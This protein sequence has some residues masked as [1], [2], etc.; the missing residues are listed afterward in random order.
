M[1]RPD[2]TH[3]IEQG[4][5]VYALAEATG[6]AWP[7]IWDDPKNA[8]LKK[9]RSDPGILLPGDVVHIPPLRK[10][11]ESGSDAAKHRF[12]RLSIPLK[13]RIRLQR[14]GEPRIGQRFKVTIGASSQHGN[15]DGDGIAEV[16]LPRDAR[17]AILEVG[18]GDE[19]TIHSLNLGRLDPPD[20]VSGLQARLSNLG[21][22]AGPADGRMGP[23]TRD[24]ISRFQLAHGMEPTGEPDEETIRA[25]VEAHG[26]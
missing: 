2:S 14:N 8:P 9:L 16:F 26:S 25:L 6:H 24:A 5:C 11:E 7:T 12:R 18:E 22:D 17:A 20:A 23:N 10:R 3:R 21:F 19:R 1:P 15:T 13:L 4:E